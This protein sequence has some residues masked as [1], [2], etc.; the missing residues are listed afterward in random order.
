MYGNQWTAKRVIE[1]LVVAFRRLPMTP[2]Y[3]PA[4]EIIEPAF[5][6]LPIDGAYLCQNI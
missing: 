5:F 6:T 4:A 1:R 2:I 3:S